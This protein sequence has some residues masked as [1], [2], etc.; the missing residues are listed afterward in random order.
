MKN[1]TQN[2]KEILTSIENEFTNINKV[3]EVNAN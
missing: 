3:T 1:L 2:Q